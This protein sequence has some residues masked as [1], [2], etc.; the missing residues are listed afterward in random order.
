MLVYVYLQALREEH[1]NSFV[2]ALISRGRLPPTSLYKFRS[3]SL[4]EIAV[5]RYKSADVDR[6]IGGISHLHYLRSINILVS[7]SLKTRWHSLPTWSALASTL[8]SLT[9][10]L[11]K[12]PKKS[13]RSL[14]RA[15][16]ST[17]PSLTSLTELKL[18]D[19]TLEYRESTE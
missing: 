13:R 2:N 19:T 16:E 15:L 17:I 14:S 8:Q 10:T 18:I 3:T 7:S 11:E 6:W 5:A 9:L 1:V 4:T 12:E